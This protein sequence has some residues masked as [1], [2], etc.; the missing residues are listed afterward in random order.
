MTNLLIAAALLVSQSLEEKK[1]KKLAS[2][3]LKK[4]AWLLDYDQAL[5][6]SKKSKKAIFA[7]FTRSYA[8]CPPCLALEGG[9]LMAD[10]FAKFA[11]DY[12]LY[13]NISSQ[14]ESDKH[15][16]LLEKVGGEGFPHLVF[17]DS[18]GSV[19]ATHEGAR[20]AA[21]FTKTGEKAK[22]YISLRE[23]AAA[24]DPAAK[25]D[26]LLARMEIGQVGEEEADKAIKDLGTLSP[27]QRKKFDALKS[28]AAVKATMAGIADEAGA[29]A[30]GKKFLE[31]KKAG[32]PEPLGDSEVQPYW[33]LMMQYAEKQKDVETFDEALKA[34][35]ARFGKVEEAKDFFKSADETLK[36]LKAGK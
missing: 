36:T 20:D 17:M 23:K 13:C 18:D 34:L 3:F 10:E 22:A 29:Q 26:F 14:I 8:P 11:G 33:I 21:G 32:R 9:G 1:E 12:V 30:A 31:M 27:E 15:Q 6:E 24:G 35:K 25:V 5:A 16:D 19:I 7:F 4:A 2:P 28:G